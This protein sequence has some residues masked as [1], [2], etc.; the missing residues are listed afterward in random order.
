MGTKE[1][2]FMEVLN[3]RNFYLFIYLFFYLFIFFLGGGIRGGWIFLRYYK[4]P[5]HQE[6]FFMCEGEKKVDRMASSGATLQTDATALTQ[7][8]NIPK[9]LS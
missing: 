8:H 9:Q 2:F 5:F 7:I 3:I 4:I 1:S 6:Y